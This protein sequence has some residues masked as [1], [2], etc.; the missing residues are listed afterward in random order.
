MAMNMDGTKELL[1]TT[2]GSFY[3]IQVLCPRCKGTGMEAIW[4]KGPC[5]HCHG[6]KKI[7]VLRWLY[8]QARKKAMN[9]FGKKLV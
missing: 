1:E 8:C 2:D 4:P 5:S 3:P 9:Q 6:R 7:T